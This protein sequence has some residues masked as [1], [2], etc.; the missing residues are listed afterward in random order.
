M[1][2]LLAVFQLANLAFFLAV[3]TGRSLYLWFT[4][5][6]NPFAL[7]SGKRGLPR[8]LELALLPWLALW[9]LDILF[10]ALPAA[11]R[12]LP[13]AWDPVLFNLLPLK[14]AGIVLILA[15]DFLFAWALI[16]FGSSWRIGIDEKVA[17]GLMTGGAF[18]FSRNPIFVFLNLYFLGT[19]LLTGT[20]SFLVFILVT[21][22]GIHLQIL[23][24]ER[25]LAG[26]FGLAYRDY[27]ACT[28]R[29]FSLKRNRI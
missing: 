22:T 20:L 3:F 12:L 11:W 23:Q 2:R 1:N 18:A 24:E 5:G 26:R 19:F 4:Q 13:A 9:L 27:C 25:F 7:G 17:G 15:G 8:L 10:S 6:I 16:S 29:Y 28:G 14:I 21:I